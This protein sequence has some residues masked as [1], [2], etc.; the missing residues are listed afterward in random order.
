VAESLNGLMFIFVSPFS[1][2]FIFS[3]PTRPLIPYSTACALHYMSCTTCPLPH[4]PHHMPHTIHPH[5]APA[6]TPH[7]CTCIMHLH[8]LAHHVPHI[9]HHMPHITHHVPCNLM[10]PGHRFT[11][12]YFDHMHYS[13]SCLSLITARL[14]AT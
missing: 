8:P 12:H 2:W 7:T 10:C 1:I 11:L 9:A 4:A 6:P 14:V 5:H 3:Y 13:L